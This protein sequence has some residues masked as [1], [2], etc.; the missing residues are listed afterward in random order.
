MLTATSSQK[1][2]RR[3]DKGRD[4]DARAG[5]TD[6]ARRVMVGKGTLFSFQSSMKRRRR[7][8]KGGPKGEGR[9]WVYAHCFQHHVLGPAS[10]IAAYPAVHESDDRPPGPPR[11]SSVP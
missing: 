8:A 4:A 5:E 7:I 6:A 11:D 1:A 2:A 10:L 3:R 9:R